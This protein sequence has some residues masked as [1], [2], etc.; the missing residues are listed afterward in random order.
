MCSSRFMC[1]VLALFCKVCLVYAADIDFSF[2]Y[3]NDLYQSLKAEE[4]WQSIADISHKI[5][6]DNNLDHFSKSLVLNRLASSYFYLGDYENVLNSSMKALYHA[7]K[8]ASNVSQI[9]SLYL[10]SAAHRALATKKS[11]S[12]HKKKSLQFINHA[13]VLLDKQQPIQDCNFFIAGKVYFNAGALYQDILQNNKKAI[14][15][16]EQALTMFNHSSDDYY[17]TAIRYIRCLLESGEHNIAKIKM[18]QFSTNL[19]TKTGIHHRILKVRVYSK[20]GEFD[21][22]YKIATEALEQAKV[23]SM[24]REID[25]LDILI[26]EITATQFINNNLS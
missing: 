13:L 15:Y 9:R 18:N 2:H 26:Q 11:F 24:V 6:L 17:R 21:K 1:T 7:K 14:W 5:L 22:A 12:N 19:C 8:S 3:Y 25:M 20:L 23:K 10:L 4:K 16:Y